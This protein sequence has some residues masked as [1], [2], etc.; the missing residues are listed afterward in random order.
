[1][2]KKKKSVHLRLPFLKINRYFSKGTQSWL[3]I[4]SFPDILFSIARIAIKGVNG[5]GTNLKTT[6]NRN[7]KPVAIPK[8][9]LF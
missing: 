2:S 6:K 1:M 8:I 5:T 4:A 3:I 7:K 9:E